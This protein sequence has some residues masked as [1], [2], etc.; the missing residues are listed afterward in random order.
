MGGP[1]ALDI[2]GEVTDCHHKKGNPLRIETQ[3]PV[4]LDSLVC[5]PTGK[6][7]VEVVCEARAEKNVSNTVESHLIE[8]RYYPRRTVG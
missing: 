4:R 3:R 8:V 5:R 7:S 1:L 2:Y 6:S